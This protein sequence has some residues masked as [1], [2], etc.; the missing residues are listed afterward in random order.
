MSPALS[1]D[2]VMKAA[3]SNAGFDD[4]GSTGFREPL[5]IL[6]ESLR[7]T[8]DLTPFGR[9]YIKA[10]VTELLANRLKLVDLWGRQPEI[11]L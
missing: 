11:R 4:F 10:M 8:G 9:F 7:E 3:I 6:L 1:L 5:A 2:A